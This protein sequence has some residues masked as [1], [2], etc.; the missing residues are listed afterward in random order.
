M[1]LMELIE[2]LFFN[3]T[4][5]F[6][7][8]SVVAAFCTILAT[9][10][11]S[12]KESSLS[13]VR[14]KYENLIF[15]LFNQLEPVLYHKKV[16][17][18]LPAILDFI[19]ENKK[20][21]DGKLLELTYFC[22]SHPSKEHFQDLCKYVDRTMDKYCHRLGIKP[23][24]MYY[25]FARNQY[26]G[27]TFWIVFISRLILLPFFI[28]FLTFILFLFAIASFS[29]LFVEQTTILQIIFILAFVLFSLIF[30]RKYY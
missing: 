21:A 2:K 27:F 7:L 24:T 30:V 28:F 26:T 25:R 12:K 20:Y 5:N 17:E 10:L 18:R 15:P 23:R 13:F 22:R 3:P 29:N 1:N 8:L 14:E 19:E 9:I 6:E 4:A 16:P 11:L